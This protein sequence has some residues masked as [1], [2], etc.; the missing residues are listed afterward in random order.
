MFDELDKISTT[1]KGEE[2]QNLL[3]HL[4]DPVQN[5]EFE[6]KYLAGVNIDLSRVM[7]TFSANDLSKIDRVLLDRMIVIQLQGYS[8]K[9]KLAI[10]ENYLLP[11][12]LK[13]VGLNEKVG[14]TKEVL[15]HL[16]KEYAS[17]ESGVRELK[18]CIEQVTQKI[19]MLRM[20]NSKDLPFHIK[21]F[22]LPF[23]VKK[24]HIDLFLKK[25]LPVD[26]SLQRM[27]I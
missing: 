27:Y 4:T 14:I 16:L 23:V 12:A 15:E 17:E 7:F 13:D 3:V 8:P 19:N 24:E 6:D 20:F 26:P 25:K 1:A 10:A 5:G 2:V 11:A 18:R 21:D 22:S 9:E